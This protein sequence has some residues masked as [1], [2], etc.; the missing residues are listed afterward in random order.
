VAATA[1]TFQG[2]EGRTYRLR[3][4]ER[5]LP[6]DRVRVLAA[7]LGRDLRFEPQSDAEAREE[8]G[9]S[10]PAEYADAFLSFY[11]E[12]TLDESEVLPTVLEVTGRPPRTFEQWAVAH[13]DA[14]R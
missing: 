12:G 4:P 9:R 10:M 3:G 5:L 8:M 6:A 13:A 2:H 1:L 11:G 14:F 7:L